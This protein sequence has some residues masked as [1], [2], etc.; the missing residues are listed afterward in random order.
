VA[1]KTRTPPPPR[2]VQAPKARPGS[3]QSSD[4]RSRLLLLLL[5]LGG[6]AALA[7]VVIFLSTR[8]SSTTH[9]T[10]TAVNFATLPGLQTGGPPWN[11]G[12]ASLDERLAPL[13]L[14]A[15]TAEGQVVH[16]HQHLDLYVN[17]KH[18]K[19]PAG[20]GIQPS[21]YIVTLHTHDDSGTIHFESP[22]HASHSLGQFFGIWGV[23]LS[24][25]CV[26]GACNG[27]KMW[28]N[29]KPYKGDPAKLVL[30]AHQEIVIVDGGK[31]PKKIPK[32]YNF[33]P[34]Y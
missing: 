21:D 7:A 10:P 23:Q 8:G 12:T 22:T 33:P 9:G 31:P 14:K 18:V 19:L 13:G 34:G 1:K 6:V 17:G 16:I 2:R 15:L 25:T 30:K 29:G 11:T 28:V 27:V 32:S 5:A 24:P 3:R 26:G 20:V 4:N